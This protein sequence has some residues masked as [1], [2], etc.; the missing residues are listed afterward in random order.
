M[1]TFEFRRRKPLLSLH[2][3]AKKQNDKR[4]KKNLSGAAG[5]S[6]GARL[7]PSPDLFPGRIPLQLH[8]QHSPHSVTN[9]FQEVRMACWNASKRVPGA[10][11][12]DGALVAIHATIVA[13]LEKKR[14]IPKPIATLDAF[15]ATDAKFLVDRVF[16]IRIFHETSFDSC[17]WAQTVFR[18]RIEVIWFRFEIPRA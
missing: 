6:R 10:D 8:W 2:A 5:L 18:A 17:G 12:R 16:V 1:S 11:L 14:P 13:H 3:E 15:G 4:S 7:L 9:G